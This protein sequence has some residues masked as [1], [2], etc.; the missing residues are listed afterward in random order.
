[1]EL[2]EKER[3]PHSKPA[4][5]KPFEMY[6]DNR[7]I[8]VK[9]TDLEEGWNFYNADDTQVNCNFYSKNLISIKTH[10]WQVPLF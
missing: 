1:V 10:R 9:L 5:E 7:M 3:F 2:A 4:R 6:K 8:T